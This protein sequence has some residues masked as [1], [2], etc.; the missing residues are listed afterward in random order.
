MKKIFLFSALA[1]G[2]L[3]TGCNDEVEGLNTSNGN[4]VKL[5]IDGPASRV[6]TDGNASSFEKDDQIAIN[7]VGL[8]PEMENETFTVG[9]GGSLETEETFY[10][11][12]NKSATFYAHYPTTATY[13]E[14][15]VSVTVPAI[16][17]SL[18][19]YEATDFMT[20]T[21]TGSPST[22]NGGVSLKFTHRLSLVKITWNGSNTATDIVMKS[23]KPTVTWTH[24]TDALTTSGTATDIVMW[25]VDPKKQEYWVLIPP[26]TVAK[27][28]TLL[29]IRDGDR[30]YPYLPAVDLTFND[31]NIRK[32]TLDTKEENGTTEVIATSISIESWGDDETIANGDLESTVL[33]KSILIDETTGK[34]SGVTALTA[35]TKKTTQAG[36]WGFDADTEDGAKIELVTCPEDQEA[37]A[38]HINIPKFKKDGTTETKWYENALY[39]QLSDEAASTIKP[40][41]NYKLTFMLRSNSLDK[42]QLRMHVVRA[43]V[44]NEF[45]PITQENSR[46]EGETT[47]IYKEQEFGA[48][49]ET[50]KDDKTVKNY[51]WMGAQYPFTSPEKDGETYV[52]KKEYE[53]KTYYV[54]FAQITTA[55]NG[56]TY[57]ENPSSI[58][59]FS[60]VALVF[61]V[62]TG[63]NVDF[64]IKDIKLEEEE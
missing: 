54:N 5:F 15:T 55:G 64:Y 39:Y 61:A 31:K 38:I 42:K 29:E 40:G 45:F 14:G 28:T 48:Y 9:E 32:I 23:L 43:E 34:F 59:D 53:P 20:S 7:S 49:Y 27:G 47:L 56:S 57:R 3:L 6:V 1:L 13:N 50:V 36:V 24:A 8:A 17:S 37:K 22:N 2:T 11:D 60:H 10:Y 18:E 12:G 63:H 30:V 33:P 26:Q 21:A 19:Q 16:Q 44:D 58:A 35:L 62:N 25:K 52:E 4:E 46:K 41:K 51:Y